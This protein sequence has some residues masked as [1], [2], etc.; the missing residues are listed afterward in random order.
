MYTALKLFYSE[1]DTDRVPIMNVNRKRKL[2]DEDMSA[3]SK[4]EL[5]ERIEQLSVHNKQL[6]NTILKQSEIP[7][8]ADSFKRKGRPFDFSK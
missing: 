4:E 6:R 5:M 1:F 2:E 8:N 7:S 3:L